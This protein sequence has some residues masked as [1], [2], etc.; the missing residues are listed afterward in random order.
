VSECR[1][2]SQLSAGESGWYSSFEFHRVYHALHDFCAVDLSAFYFDVLKDR[3]YTSAP[4]NIGRRSAQTA[5]YR[6]A[7]ALVRLFAPIIVFTSEEVWKELPEVRLKP[8]SVHMALFPQAEEL[9]PGVDHK[10]T[11]NWNRLLELREEVLRLLE[12]ARTAKVIAGSL[13]ARVQ[14]SATGDFAEFLDKYRQSLR[15]LYIVSDVE[16]YHESIADAQSAGRAAHIGIVVPGGL[17]YGITISR[18]LGSKCERCWNYSTHVGEDPDDPRI[19][20][21]CVAALREIE[22]QDG[23]GSA[24]S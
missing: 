9:Y 23:K 24:G 22:E 3:L 17:Q 2:Y 13:E 16:V 6:I 14:Y 10:L 4:R 8:C 15:A 7:N 11:T 19:C 5:I 21:R 1:G 12:Q 20:E 18:A